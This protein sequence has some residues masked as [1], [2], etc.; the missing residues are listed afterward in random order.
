MA[1]KIKLTK[2]QRKVIEL[3]QRGEV[4]VHDDRYFQ[5]SDKFTEHRIQW[6]VWQALTQ[7]LNLIR[8]EHQPHFEWILTKEGENIKL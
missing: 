7:E 6:K 5:V 3:L 8:Q 1:S 2:A 4:I